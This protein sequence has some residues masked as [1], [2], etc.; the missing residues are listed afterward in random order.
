MCEIVLCLCLT[1]HEPWYPHGIIGFFLWFCFMLDVRHVQAHKILINANDAICLSFSSFVWL[2][3]L[4]SHLRHRHHQ[5]YKMQTILFVLKG[6]NSKFKGYE[7]WTLYIIKSFGCKIHL[8]F[9][10]SLRII[11]RWFDRHLIVDS[12]NIELPSA[13]QIRNILSSIFNFNEWN[14]L[15]YAIDYYSHTA[16]KTGFNFIHSSCNLFR[17]QCN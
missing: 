12:L 11:R 4:T 13:I 9:P 3:G 10:I 2:F 15:D 6:N 5:N 1:C 17:F 14:V 8:S 16:H 7:L